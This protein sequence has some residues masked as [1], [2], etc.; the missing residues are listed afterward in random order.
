MDTTSFRPRWLSGL[1]VLATIALGLASRRWPGL[2]PA[3][4]EKYPGD[5]LWAQMVYWLG[6]IVLPGASV[7]RLAAAALAVAWGVEFSQLWHPPWLDAIRATTPGHLVLGSAF[8]VAD[9]LAYAIG[10]ALVAGLDALVHAARRRWR[11]LHSAP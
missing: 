8:G 3:V 10:I 4:L 1:L 2:F 11:G 7:R 9:L 6:A 5:A